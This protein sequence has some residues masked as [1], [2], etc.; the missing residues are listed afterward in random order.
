MSRI[1]GS[2]AGEQ[3]ERSRGMRIELSM[4]ITTPD[5][6]ERVDHQPSSNAQENS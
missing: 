1:G 4:M 6:S 2:A 5:A 3:R